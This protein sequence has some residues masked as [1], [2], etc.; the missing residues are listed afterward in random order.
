MKP[1]VLSDRDGYRLCLTPGFAALVSPEGKP[2]YWTGTGKETPLE[3]MAIA[4]A[5]AAVEAM[6]RARR[7]DA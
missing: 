1:K 3:G 7:G 6:D 2:L 5:C 4:G